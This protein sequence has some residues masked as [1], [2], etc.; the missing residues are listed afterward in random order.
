MPRP[1]NSNAD[2]CDSYGNMCFFTKMQNFTYQAENCNC[3][4]KCNTVKFS[5]H[6]E[7]SIP[8]KGAKECDAPVVK[9]SG[10]KISNIPMSKFVLD[11][12]EK[13]ISNE[14]PLDAKLLTDL[15]I[16]SK[17]FCTN[18]IEKD[19]AVIEVQIE[20]Q[21]Y[22]KMRQSLRKTL[23]DKLG[24]LGGTLGLF[25]GF[26]FMAI[27]ELIYW[28]LVILQRIFKEATPDPNRFRRS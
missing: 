3:I 4:P 14:R 23:G 1:N 21:S 24:E 12:V 26:S 11:Q 16:I 25:T 7:S 10:S 27:V 19:F 13:N 9:Y 18:S 2:L 15:S 17:D 6:F 20:G 28:I 8:L 22:I 5:S